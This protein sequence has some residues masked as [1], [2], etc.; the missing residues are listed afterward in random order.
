MSEGSTEELSPVDPVNLTN[1]RRAGRSRC[2]ISDEGRECSKCHT[3][4]PWEDYYDSVDN[5]AVHDKMSACKACIRAGN[6]KR[7]AGSADI[8]KAWQRAYASTQ[9]HRDNKLNERLRR[10]GIT[11]AAFDVALAGVCEICGTKFTTRKS[12]HLDHNHT[13]GAFRGFL[14]QGCNHGLGNFRDSP[15]VLRKAAAFLERRS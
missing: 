2:I 10:R 15:E 7:Y 4:L 5:R 8:R 12:M 13:T 11:R 1:Y 9:G 6:Q 3:F 14:C